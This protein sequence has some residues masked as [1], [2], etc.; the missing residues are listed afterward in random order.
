MLIIFFQERVLIFLYLFYFI[1]II[2]I[3]IYGLLLSSIFDT[4][5]ILSFFTLI[6]LDIFSIEIYILF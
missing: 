4:N 6:L 3:L 1:S 2:I 5:L